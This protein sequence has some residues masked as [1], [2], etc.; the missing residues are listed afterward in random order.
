MDSQSPSTVMPSGEQAFVSRAA[1][2][3]VG[4]TTAARSGSGS[5]SW[6][7]WFTII[8]V[9]V[10]CLLVYVVMRIRYMD[11][12][13]I[14]VRRQVPSYRAQHHRINNG[15]ENW[16]ADPE[17][18]ARLQK[19]VE[20]GE[21]QQAPSNRV[22]QTPEPEPMEEERP[23][24]R[25]GG[26]AGGNMLSGILGGCGFD[27]L[28]SL[29]GGG[30]GGG[31]GPPPPGRR[32]PPQMPPHGFTPGPAFAVHIGEFIHDEPAVNIS[33]IEEDPR[34]A[35]EAQVETI[36]ESASEPA[37]EPAASVSESTSEPAS[38]STTDS[39]STVEEKEEKKDQ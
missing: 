4:S 32:P 14:D 39:E 12:Q 22:V 17:N 2:S 34:Q 35:H 27:F 8:F 5:G 3:A 23:S 9:F 24:R 13:V 15:I 30:G 28:G 16:L 18:I 29:M 1:P 21:P 6:W 26:G 20:S 36:A 31:T 11:Q 37:S 19:I 33:E 7:L 25:G 38:E 10:A